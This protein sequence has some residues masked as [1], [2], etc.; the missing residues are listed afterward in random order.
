MVMMNI[1]RFI[2]VYMVKCSTF[3]IIKH[4]TYAELKKDKGVTTYLKQ[5]A[6][7]FVSKNSKL[8]E[9][10][11]EILLKLPLSF[12]LLCSNLSFSR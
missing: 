2:F 3:A 9:F 4:F 1:Y 11:S 10:A 5:I 7:K 12:N 6:F 8:P